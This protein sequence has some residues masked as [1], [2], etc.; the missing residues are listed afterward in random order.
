MPGP[1]VPVAQCPENQVLVNGL[2]ARM[3][4]LQYGNNAGAMYRKLGLKKVAKSV[5]KYPLKLA[6]EEEMRKLEGVGAGFATMLLKLRQGEAARPTSNE[7]SVEDKLLDDAESS[8]NGKRVRS[9]S[10]ESGSNATQQS[11]P[12]KLP[13]GGRLLKMPP[14]I[15]TVVWCILVCLGR[16][17]DGLNKRILA[18]NV[19][20]LRLQQ[21]QKN[22]ALTLFEKSLESLRAGGFIRQEQNSEG[23]LPPL[24]LLTDK[25]TDVFYNLINR[26]MSQRSTKTETKEFVSED[27]ED[28]MRTCKRAR[29]PKADEYF[30]KAKIRA[31]V[32]PFCF[33][34]RAGTGCYTGF[35]FQPQGITCKSLTNT[36]WEVVLL[37]DNR[38]ESASKRLQFSLESKGVICEN[39]PLS[40]GD[41]LWVF[42]NVT[43][44]F[45]YVSDYIV[46]RKTAGDLASSIKDGR[47]KEQKL[48]L[49]NC[50]LQHVIY[51]V[52]GSLS[53]QNQTPVVILED[54]LAATQICDGFRLKRTRSHDETVEYLANQYHLI[55]ASTTHSLLRR[56]KGP[57]QDPSRCLGQFLAQNGTEKLRTVGELF[58][59]QLK[60][61]KGFSACKV[62]AILQHATTPIQMFRLYKDM[63]EGGA[64]EAL[65]FYFEEIRPNGQ[66]RK[67][68]KLASSK[69]FEM[70]SL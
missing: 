27:V 55:Q 62:E 1:S 51:L 67:L 13:V 9:I 6:T 2:H 10:A 22:V 33:T 35:E 70:F 45:K 43:T 18:Q 17:P 8:R 53:S 4:Q 7:V 30:P 69:L 49:H 3:R 46:E 11:G 28:L 36:E 5:S 65:R 52:E 15:G 48:R 63:L 20:D 42:R 21:G 57:N 39:L 44:G 66:S 58:A 25:G 56:W 16:T 47:F 24:S 41:Y 31:S 54:A 38:E 23:P 19:D 64:D 37:I 32:P 34:P 12:G 60:Q 50:G 26:P 29:M 61:I 59:A 68:G 40:L 14:A